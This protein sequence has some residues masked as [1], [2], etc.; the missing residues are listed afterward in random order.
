LQRFLSNCGLV[1]GVWQNYTL[2]SDNYIQHLSNNVAV[3]HEPKKKEITSLHN[4][5][6]H[7]SFVDTTTAVPDA[8]KIY[9]QDTNYYYGTIGEIKT[10]SNKNDTSGS[11]IIPLNTQLYAITDTLSEDELYYLKQTV[12]RGI[13]YNLQDIKFGNGHTH[14]LIT[15]FIKM[16][17]YQYEEAYHLFCCSRAVNVFHCFYILNQINTHTTTET[18][19]TNNIT[20]Q[21]DSYNTAKSTSTHIQKWTENIYSTFA[22]SGITSS[23]DSGI[24]SSTDYIKKLIGESYLC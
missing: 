1:R 3:K 20:V 4:G 21:I 8:T 18:D 14:G 10:Q 13:V 2:L 22:D 17:P 12:V 6:N 16:D 15:K 24:T 5:L 19:V 23:T 9:N 7:V 11:V